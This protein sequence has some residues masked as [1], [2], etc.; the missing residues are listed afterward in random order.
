MN[1]KIIGVGKCGSRICYDFFAHI[2]GLPSAYEIRI[3]PNASAI[4][5]LF[6]A[7]QAG[8]GFNE[9]MATWRREWQY[10]TGTELLK[11]TAWYAIVDSDVANNE[12]TQSVVFFTK[13]DGLQEKTVFPGTSHNLSNH[14]GGCDFHI[15][16]ENICQNWP[17]SEVPQELCSRGE[18]EIVC[19]AFAIGGG[20]G[21]GAGLPLASKMQRRTPG[22]ETKQVHLMG[23]GILP[24]SDEP[25]SS[26]DHHSDMDP[27][28]KFNVGR[29]FT[30][31]YGERNKTGT[32]RFLDSLWLVSNDCLR[33]MQPDGETR[34][35][36]AE[37]EESRQLINRR[38][39]SLINMSLSGAMCTLCN[40]S[41]KGTT[42]SANFDA[43]EMNN[44]MNGNPFISAFAHGKADANNDT[45]KD[46]A[47]VHQ[48]FRGT[49]S[50]PWIQADQLLGLSAPQHSAEMAA[51]D[52]I[53]GEDLFAPDDLPRRFGKYRFQDGPIAF[54]TAQKVVVLYGQS[55]SNPSDFR[56]RLVRQFTDGLFPNSDISF[57][58][59]KHTG[60][61]EYLVL[62]VVNPFLP[63]IQN[64]MYYYLQ[65]SWL[66]NVEDGSAFLDEVIA[67]P[68]F[69]EASFD[70][71]LE[72]QERLERDFL[73]ES[74]LGVV[75]KIG[76]RWPFT[77]QHV[78]DSM[79]SL[80]SIYHHKKKTITRSKLSSAGH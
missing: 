56:N 43:M 13:S 17:E 12:I 62:L 50:N 52:C 80:H 55:D 66:K 6:E 3:Q 69:S 65:R 39:I 9:R 20:T 78:I 77:K 54:R 1:I 58:A 19:Y 14:T 15:V 29:F 16:S 44:R 23:V 70:D 51:L 37:A 10:L 28:E 24:E 18:A 53:F 41:S 2:S 67:T 40:S 76:K 68:K 48:L 64:A 60:L 72:D 74:T 5:K 32:D 30:S 75:A 35:A 7:I 73:G 47:H 61:T 42:S 57:Y 8:I 63:A 27:H 46:I 38:G 11:D 33:W 4:S 26:E 49:V 45:E 21:G 31:W 36:A 59:Y 25:Y 22:P 79:R 71:K 34:R